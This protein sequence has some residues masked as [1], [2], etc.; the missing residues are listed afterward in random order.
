MYLLVRS[1][2]FSRFCLV[3]AYEFT[4][5]TSVMLLDSFS[6]PCALLLSKL[7]LG[8]KFTKRHYAGVLMCMVGMTVTILSD[9]EPHKGENFPDS[10]HRLVGDCIV[11]FGAFLMAVSNVIQEPIMKNHDKR[12]F[13]GM[14]GLFGV[15]ISGILVLI[16][17]KQ[18]LTSAEL[19][20]TVWGY[21]MSYT[22]ASAGQ[23]ILLSIFLVHGDSTLFNLSVATSDVYSMLFA[24]VVEHYEVDGIYLLGFCLI[25]VGLYVYNTVPSP[26]DHGYGLVAHRNGNGEEGNFVRLGGDDGTLPAS[27]ADDDG[28]MEM[29]SVP[30]PHNGDE[31]TKRQSSNEADSRHG[32]RAVT[33]VNPAMRPA[34]SPAGN[35]KMFSGPY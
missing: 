18:D 11:L 4:S 23:Y 33:P 10:E 1:D 34:T 15:F 24:F 3:Y 30:T 13:L 26:N 6:V 21:L 17:E 8:A 16:F 2:C 31:T 32:P 25:V 29:V 27:T 14:V 28:V 20:P 5:I 7:Y 9:F 19:T 12:E 35:G 22:I